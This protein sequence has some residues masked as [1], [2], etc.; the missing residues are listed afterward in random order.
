MFVLPG[1]REKGNPPTILPRDR[2]GKDCCGQVGPCY[3][4]YA[5]NNT[6][7]AAVRLNYVTL[8][9]LQIMWH[10]SKKIIVLLKNLWHLCFLFILT[11]NI[12]CC[13]MK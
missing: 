8:F 4:V 2:H 6:K 11:N 5:E 12:S 7:I 1:Q 9:I 13:P 10:N 3:V